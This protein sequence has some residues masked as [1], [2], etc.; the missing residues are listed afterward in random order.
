MPKILIVDDRPINRDYVMTLLAASGYQLMEASDGA[1]ALEQVRSGRPD[2]VIADVLMPTMDGYEFCRQLRRDPQIAETPVI[3]LTAHYADTVAK[4][5]AE[6]CGVHHIMTKP[7]EPEVILTTVARALGLP[8]PNLAPR[9]TP[10]TFQSDHLRLLTDTLARKANELEISN[11]Q[12]KALIELGLQLAAERDPKRMLT[13]FCHTAGRIVESDYAM[14]AVRETD[15]LHLRH[16]LAT[17]VDPATI[18]RITSPAAIDSL[19]RHFPLNGSTVL[20]TDMEADPKA[21]LLH[22]DYEAL[23]SVVISP[24]ASA[25]TEYGLLC[26]GGIIGIAKPNGALKSLA[27]SLAAQIAINYENVIRDEQIQ[28]HSANLE[29]EVTERKRAQEELDRLNA[30]LEQ[31]VQER[32]R[33]LEKSHQK[34]RNSERMAAIGTLSAGLGHDM[35]NLLFPIRI[36]LDAMQQSPVS[37][38]MREHIDAVRKCMDYLQTLTNGLRMLSLDPDDHEASA[39]LTDLASWRSS[40]LPLLKSALPRGVA[41]KCD[42]PE[43]GVAA[44][45]IAPH[46]LTQAVFNLVNNSCDA[47]RERGVGHITITFETIAD[48]SMAKIS[49]SDDGPGMSKDVRKRVLEPFFTTKKRALSTG[50]G[51]SLVH[52]IVEAAGGALEIDSE[53]GRGTCISMTIPWADERFVEPA[54]SVTE[55]KPIAALAVAD[56]RLRALVSTV[57]ESIGYRVRPANGAGST[58]WLDVRVLLTDSGEGALR[59]AEGFLAHR[60]DRRV[61]VFGE[62]DDRWRRLGA[63]EMGSA[64][65]LSELRT[66]LRRL[67]PAE[68]EKVS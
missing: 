16:V 59:K 62:T 48:G 14:V 12:L 49:V 60:D 9:A 18:G 4:E 28:R 31:R 45:R 32:S 67:A 63:I 21:R 51:L 47:L 41:L 40:L 24:I 43:R 44:L 53:V 26:F 39:P 33:E 35:G 66:A 10:S 8:A 46:R 23:H 34:L 29:K 30:E 56:D 22:S 61:A 68:V 36:R 55:S 5:L 50:L 11:R 2:L 6:N 52:S 17:G 64:C 42:I 7:V 54:D 65:R 1:E 58:E 13:D 19:F 25:T 20:I 27:S 57:L 15:G 37:P 38:D 3:F